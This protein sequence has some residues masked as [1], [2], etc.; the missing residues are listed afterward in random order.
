MVPGHQ[1]LGRVALV[2]SPGGAE[3]W[4]VSTYFF[5]VI[6]HEDGLW[7]CR[8]G[9]A[10]LDVH[11]RLDDAIEHT[12]RIASQYPPSEVFVHHVDGRVQSIATLE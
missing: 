9:R 11:A 2:T 10:D 4:G 7:S 1:I 12:T 8:R 3:C 5:R 6:E